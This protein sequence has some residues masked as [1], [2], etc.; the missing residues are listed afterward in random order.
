MSKIWCDRFLQSYLEL[1]DPLRRIDQYKTSYQEG[2][3]CSAAGVEQRIS[4]SKCSAAGV[5]QRISS[6][7]CSAAG[8]EQRIS[9]NSTF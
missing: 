8:V 2:P 4:N 1:Q 6:L 7:K 9:K 5:E 3:Q